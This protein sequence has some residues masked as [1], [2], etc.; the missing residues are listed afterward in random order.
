[1]S[2]TFFTLMTNRDIGAVQAALAAAHNARR[3]LPGIK[4]LTKTDAETKLGLLQAIACIID[5][6]EGIKHWQEVRMQRRA[7]RRE[8]Q[9]P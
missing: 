7:E 4:S 5:N 3:S 2:A 9:T 8:R 6:L 1:M